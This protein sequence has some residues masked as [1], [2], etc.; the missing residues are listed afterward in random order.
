VDSGARDAAPVDASPQCMTFCKCMAMNCSDKVFP[1]GCLHDC[2]AGTNWDLPCRQNMC[3]LAPAQPANDH[4]THAM[5][6]NE[7]LDK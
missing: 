3:G 7:C 2:A 1:G 6:V 4:C 5:G